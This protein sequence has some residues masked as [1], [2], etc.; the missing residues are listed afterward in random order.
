MVKGVL[1]RSNKY[2]NCLKMSG[3]ML[4]NLIIENSTFN[5]FLTL[6]RSMVSISKTLGKCISI[7][8]LWEKSLEISRWQIKQLRLRPWREFTGNLTDI[9]KL[10]GNFRYMS[11]LGSNL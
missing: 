10:V 11:T 3:D 4:V 7:Q 6:G 1:C 2:Q 8:Q 5:L 9:K